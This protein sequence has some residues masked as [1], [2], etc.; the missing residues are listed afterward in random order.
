MLA[1]H[2]GVQLAQTGYPMYGAELKAL[3]STL[4]EFCKQ[5]VV[6]LSCT[7]ELELSYMRL[8]E[9]KPRVVWEISPADGFSTLVI[10]HALAANGNN[11]SLHSFDVFSS[12]QRWITTER[13]PLLMPIWN[14]HRRNA[15]TLVTAEGFL[16][17]DFPPPDYLY[18]DS[19]HNI[20]MAT[21]YTSRLLPAVQQLGHTPIS[22]HDVYNPLFWTDGSGKRDFRVLPNWLPNLEGAMVLDWLAYGFQSD[23]CNL[24]TIAPS[25]VGNTQHHA[26]V[27]EIRESRAGMKPAELVDRHHGKCPEPTIYFE[28]NCSSVSRE[29][30]RRHHNRDNVAKLG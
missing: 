4:N 1:P 7:L 17:P 21:M 9:L 24:F 20:E 14:F 11:A 12:S 30:R 8:R 23:S 29:L 5:R 22:L 25:K 18:L 16:T 15:A 28:L 2:L 13:F 27:L 3:H 10:L 19:K 6:C 26:A